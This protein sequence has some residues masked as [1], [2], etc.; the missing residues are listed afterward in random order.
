MKP[1]ISK[2]ISYKGFEFKSSLE[3]MFCLFLEEIQAL[4]FIEK[5]GYEDVKFKLSD[6]IYLPYKVQMKTK[7]KDTT[8]FIMR[9]NTYQPDFS[10]TWS[11]AGRN[12]WFLDRELPI[13]G[14]ISDIP[15]R[16]ANPAKLVSL[17]EVKPVYE[18]LDSSIEFPVHQ[19]W[20]YQ[21]YNCLVTKIKVPKIFEQ[22]FVPKEV[23][24]TEVYLRDCPGGLK[25]SSRF[26]FETRDLQEYLKL[27]GYENNTN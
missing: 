9:E 4:G 15:F 3:Y 24:R 11:E 8:E 14:N 16:L 19:K 10:I 21:K 26:K 17:V 12:I 23:L 27:R 22:T 5:F 2:K 20:V 1:I 7:I 25:G 13:N 6:S 18:T